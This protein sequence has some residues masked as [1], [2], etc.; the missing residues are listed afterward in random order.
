MPPVTT[1]VTTLSQF[2]PVSEGTL[3]TAAGN[4]FYKTT[5]WKGMANDGTTQSVAQVLA[6]ACLAAPSCV[7]FH[8]IGGGR[9]GEGALLYDSDGYTGAWPP[10]TPDA[11]AAAG[12]GNSSW[13]EA[14]SGV[15]GNSSWNAGGTGWN[16]RGEPAAHGSVEVGK[17]WGGW[18]AFRRVRASPPSSP[19]PPPPSPSPPP[20]P[21]PPTAPVCRVLVSRQSVDSDSWL[22]TDA[23][24][25]INPLNPSAAQFS[26]LDQLEG[27]G[28]NPDD[29]NKILF[30]LYW[31]ELEGTPK[32]P[33]Q[34]WKQSSNPVTGVPGAAV[35]GF[36]A[37]DAPYIGNYW[38]GLQ[39]SGLYAL[40]D[41]SIHGSWWYAVG[42]RKVHNG[43]IPGPNGIVV[44]QTELYVHM[45]CASPSPPPPFAL[46]EWRG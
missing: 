32:G 9:L 1:S 5:M 18:E 36:E 29:D 44:S 23:E 19:S 3:V 24:W 26:I 8:L 37:V 16:G 46:P 11:V 34:L 22:R 38:G 27:M 35:E 43:G 15:S 40:L 42:A 6:V 17:G 14:A 21:T 4:E 39:R 41:G 20:S 10:E 12:A 28:R 30:E 13:N 7:G 31:P 33:R 25:S 2:V 45:P